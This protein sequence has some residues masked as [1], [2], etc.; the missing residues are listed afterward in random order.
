MNKVFSV[1]ELNNTV[2]YYLKN[3]EPDGV[4]VKGEILGFKADKRYASFL[5]CEKEEGTNNIVGQTQV[6]CWGSDFWDME[7]KLRVV[8]RTL[9]LKDGVCVQLKCQFDLWAKA[10]RFQLIAK[11][12][13]PSITLGEL[14]LLRAKIYNELKELGLHDKNKEQRI[15]LCPLRIAL[16]ASRG[17]AGFND[18]ISEIKSSK[19][20]FVI[21]F[22]HAAVQGEKVEEEVLS[23]IAKIV[24]RKRDYDVVAI[25]RGGGAVT[26]LKWFDNK[27]IGIAIS[28]CPIPVFTGIGHEINL[29]VTDMV[30]NMNFKTPTAVA[31]FLIQSVSHYEESLSELIDGVYTEA[32]AFLSQVETKLYETIKDINSEGK[33]Y[34]ESSKRDISEIVGNL[35]VDLSH[36]LRSRREELEHLEEKVAIFDP[37]NTL[38]FGY[39]I[40]RDSNGK[41]VKKIEDVDIADKISISLQNGDICGEVVN[42]EAKHGR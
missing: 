7:R 19:Y 26:D 25:V 6:M 15:S 21:D 23:A 3:L 36:F 18:F 2:K 1:S 39:S 41:I 30:A 29:S 10:G 27:K 20:P 16:V 28:E 17:S 34:I 5:L 24:K 32:E 9:S 42:K 37:I 40:T 33:F 38:R 13:E 12:I 8:D 14:H 11:D 35:T 31:S 4:W 22:Y